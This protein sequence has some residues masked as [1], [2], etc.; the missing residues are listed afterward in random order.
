MRI[1]KNKVKDALLISDIVQ[2]YSDKFET[3][4]KTITF[5]CP[6][7]DDHKLGSCWAYLDAH[8]FTC[9]A[10]KERA[11]VLRLTSQYAGIPLSD[12][13]SLLER[14]VSDFGLPKEQFAQDGNQNFKG[15]T[16]IDASELLTEEEYERLLKKARF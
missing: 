10:C 15:Y 9:S 1:D 7:H 16:K 14:I 13:N 6:F 12:M 8:A 5:L 3:H 4:G 2:K 11:D